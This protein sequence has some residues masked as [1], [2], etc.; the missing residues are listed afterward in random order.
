MDDLLSVPFIRL[1]GILIP[2]IL[3]VAALVF[4]VLGYSKGLQELTCDQQVE[5]RLVSEKPK[6]VGI[7]DG[8]QVEGELREYEF[9]L[10]NTGN[11]EVCLTNPGHWA[12]LYFKKGARILESEI[13]ECPSLVMVKLSKTADESGVLLR[14]NS[15]LVG[16]S[17]R[18]RVLVDGKSAKVNF[19]CR[20]GG[21]RQRFKNTVPKGPSS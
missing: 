5:E 9:V 15:L 16:E 7:Y 1:V 6:L 14:F 11:S 10:K 8:R 3:G 17:I 13:V 4:N 12:A 19:E 18:L 20:G 2:I 21:I